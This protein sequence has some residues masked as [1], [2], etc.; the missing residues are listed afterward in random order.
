MSDDPVGRIL[1]AIERLRSEVLARLDRLDAAPT[2]SPDQV[3]AEIVAHVQGVGDIEGKIGDWIGERRSGRWIEGFSFAPQLG[4][5]PGEILYRVVLGRDQVSPWTPAGKFCGSMGLAQPLRGIGFMLRGAA[6]AKFACG[7]N[8]TFVD[9]SSA[10]LVSAGQTCAAATFAPLEAFQI[11][12]HP[13]P[14]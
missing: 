11:I 4:V 9:G 8:A 10:G 2:G 7:C 1:S 14:A 6:A 12:L 3:P 13:R 5:D